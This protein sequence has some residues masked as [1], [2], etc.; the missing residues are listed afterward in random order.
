MRSGSEEGSYLGGDLVP[1]R[2]REPGGDLQGIPRLARAPRGRR[3]RYVPKSAPYK[4]LK[5]IAWR[6][7]DF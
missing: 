5:L 3:G 7:V 6:Q 2:H 4:A 1:G